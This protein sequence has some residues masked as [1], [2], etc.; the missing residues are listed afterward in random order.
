MSSQPVFHLLL[1][2]NHSG[3]GIHRN[4]SD[5][6]FD[7]LRSW[8]LMLQVDEV[9]RQVVQNDTFSYINH[10]TDELLLHVDA[11]ALNI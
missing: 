8:C 2:V 3:Y 1:E 11:R 9:T 4:T 5:L 10:Q 7:K 6:L